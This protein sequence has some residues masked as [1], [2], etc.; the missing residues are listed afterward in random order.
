MISTTE[1]MAVLEQEI[2]S[3]ARK[4][5]EFLQVPKESTES[6]N[7]K[8]THLKA[9]NPPMEKPLPKSLTKYYQ[10]CPF[11]HKKRNF[12][13][14]LIDH[15]K[16]CDEYQNVLKES[17]CP[18]CQENVPES[19][20]ELKAGDTPVFLAVLYFL[21]GFNRSYFDDMYQYMLQGDPVL[22]ANTFGQLA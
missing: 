1:N 2:V 5:L 6:K 15:V 18:L 10:T 20:S 13:E 21:D 3:K 11:C 14:E 4:K 19:D 12:S 17:K 8:V 16:S 22:G 7:K 9:L